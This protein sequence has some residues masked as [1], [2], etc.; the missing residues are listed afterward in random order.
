MKDLGVLHYFLG[1]KVQPTDQGL[2]LC[3]TKYAIDLLQRAS[4]IDAKPISMP[5]VVGQH[6]TAEGI[7]YIDPTLFRLL[8]G[9]LQHLTITWPDLLFSVN[10]ICQFMHAPTEDHFR[11]LKRILRYIKGTIH[12]GFQLQQQSTHELLAY[13]DADWASCPN[14]CRFTTSYA[15][16]LGSN[17]ISWSFKKQSTVSRSSAEAEYRSLVVA[18]VD[19][20]WIV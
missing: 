17:L 11:A 2:F 10:S 12:Y 18:T 19:L 1:V 14:T 20:A 5:F 9:A 4:M 16:F 8:G 6:L 13:F 3:Q 7:L 15:I